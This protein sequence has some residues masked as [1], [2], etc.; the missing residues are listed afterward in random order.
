MIKYQH[1]RLCFQPDASTIFHTICTGGEGGRITNAHL[2]FECKASMLL[3][4]HT[5]FAHVV[6]IKE[7]T[8]VKLHYD[9][10]DVLSQF[11]PMHKHSSWTR[12]LNTSSRTSAIRS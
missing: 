4:P 3:I 2:C 9:K 1:L 7:V 6:P 11:I 5:S 12:A 8:A 10:A